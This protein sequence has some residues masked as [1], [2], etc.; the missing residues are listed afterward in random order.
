[1]S[2]HVRAPKRSTQS[3]GGV[4]ASRNERKTTYPREIRGTEGAEL[5]KAGLEDFVAV[6]LDGETVIRLTKL[7][8]LGRAKQRR[9]LLY[10]AKRR[11]MVQYSKTLR[12]KANTGTKQHRAQTEVVRRVST[13]RVPRPFTAEKDKTA[14]QD[15]TKHINELSTGGGESQST[16]TPTFPGSLL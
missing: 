10:H 11:H 2:L 1:M 7:G 8:F 12:L 16:D 9:S 3:T 5:E 15:A 13:T 4:E 6:V 14:S